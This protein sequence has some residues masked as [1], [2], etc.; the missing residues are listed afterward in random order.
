MET[1]AF[2]ALRPQVGADISTVKLYLETLFRHVDWAEG[3]VISLLGIGEKGTA[4][5][6]VFRERKFVDPRS[7]FCL[8]QIQGHIERWA[9]HGI[10]AFIVPAVVASE[11]E[12]EGD[13]R[14][15]RVSA[16]TAIVLDIDSGDIG[17]KLAFAEQH[18]GY[19]TFSVMSGGYTAAGQLK[20]HAYWILSEPETDVEDVARLRKLLAA[21]IGGDQA[22]GR[23]TQVIRIP[24]SVYAKSDARA[25]VRFHEGSGRD[26][27]IDD[28]RD[29]IEDMPFMEGCEPSNV[30]QLPLPGTGGVMDFAAGAGYDQ[31]RVVTALTQE[32][33]E[34][35]EDRNRWNQFNVVAGFELSN[36]RKGLV[37]LETAFENVCKWVV[38]KMTP[39]WPIERIKSEWTGMLNTDVKNH[40]PLVAPP[41]PGD[42]IQV[43]QGL[44]RIDTTD[45]LLSWSVGKRSHEEPA[46]RVQLVEGLVYGAKRHLFVAEGGAGKTFL[47]M[48]LALKLAAASPDRALYW[49][50]QQVMPEAYG[51]HVIILT[52]EDDVDELDIRWQAL[53]PN[54]DL[55]AAAG[56]RLIALPM[57]NLGG[58]FP[59]VAYHPHTREPIAS[60]RWAKLYA[61]IKGIEERGGWVSAVM[62][63]TLNSTLHGE[64]NSASVIGEYV[65]AVAPVCGDL[66]AALLV[67]HHIRKV[68]DQPIRDLDDMKAAIRGST[69]LP[70][71]MRVVIGFW[72]A[73]DYHKQMKLMGVPPVRGKLYC[74][75]VLKSNMPSFEGVKYLL[76][77]DRGVLNDVSNR[78]ASVR[79]NEGELFAWLLYCVKEYAERYG[80]FFQK[81][82][83]TH[84]IFAQKEFLPPTLGALSRTDLQ[85]MVQ[86]LID[87]GR[88]IQRSIDKHGT[89]NVWLD[90]A[91]NVYVPRT[92]RDLEIA[93]PKLDFQNAY[94]D[95]QTR[96]VRGYN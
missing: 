57:D 85:E 58:A 72:H 27:H 53:D 84:G 6:G 95:T 43:T 14:L 66:K 28:L 54:G 15:E 39:A 59:L 49:M 94:Y 1:E 78:A 9:A 77:D 92:R 83:T 61:A 55:R 52:G 82:S 8:S 65:R 31:N 12:A 20:Q 73:H 50:G 42:G 81:S 24:G 26:C 13:V 90:L 91:E 33:T 70:N 63:D 4:K 86:A 96:T 7:A 67:S 41:P 30:I 16:L 11:A 76:R 2:S 64:E 68:G 5:E 44:E 46:P 19:A 32:I 62:M 17:A 23:A 71:A 3:G 37:D 22:F 48:D 10:A 88:L 47:M 21:K 74:A 79:A 87:T 80:F 89:G 34:G 56:D 38:A 36:Y 69:A 29:A 25:P 40:G 93:V 35:G 18:L 60:D 51:G 75:G 45:D